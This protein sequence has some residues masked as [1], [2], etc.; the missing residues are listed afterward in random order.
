MIF[1]RHWMALCFAGGCVCGFT[2]G[3]EPATPSGPSSSTTGESAS[4]PEPP[5][6]SG[7]G[8]SSAFGTPAGGS[9]TPE[10][11]AT[12]GEA[13]GPSSAFGSEGGGAPKEAAPSYTI[14]GFYGLP[15][16]TL[17]GGEG[18]LARPRFRFGVTVAQGYDDNIFQSPSD[19]QEIPDLVVVV[20]PGTPDT[21]EFVQETKI[22]GYRTRFF[23]GILKVVPITETKLVPKVIPGREPVTQTIKFPGYPD[24]KG[25]L[26]SRA[27][28]DA[29]V[30]FFTRRSLFT[31]DFQGQVDHYWDR[32]G[33][34]GPDDFSGSLA[35]AYLYSLT[36]RMQVSAAAN[37]AYIS[38]PDFT[39][40]NTPER[41]GASDI[42][43][44]LGRLNL[45]YRATPR[46]TVTASAS[47]NAVIFT[48]K[49][50]DPLDVVG[51]AAVNGD[52]FETTFGVE[53]RYLWNPRYTLLAE[54]RRSFIAYPDSPFLD[55]TTDYAL[56][57]GE[58]R[59]TSRLTVTLRLGQTF[60]TFDESG[61]GSS[62]FYGESS[63]FYRLGPT[64]AL[65]WNSRYG[66]EPPP[67]AE[68]EQ[69][70]YRSALSYLRSFTPR[71]SLNASVAGFYS[72]VT[73]DLLD[74]EQRD[75][76]LSL[77]LSLDYRMSRHLTLNANFTYYKTFSQN[78]N[79]E[80]DRSRLFIG[81]E[82]AF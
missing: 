15:G 75:T 45:A 24:R 60:R 52:N 59:F 54:Y 41:L 7:T 9:Q 14:P 74:I 22:I 77:S 39:R 44:A 50:S 6:E 31:A 34:S 38:Q 13:P 11:P 65:Q 61:S 51:T 71:L 10:S 1:N 80:Y 79:L 25:S 35:L 36:P 72:T 64:S 20:D 55:A 16:T 53:G 21:V 2:F 28:L 78:S 30:Q 27:G 12:G 8:A 48:K 46:L 68:S 5:R 70:T 18:R 62:S 81:G 47:Q 4:T 56:I 63:V 82:Y 76:N 66:F 40:I 19:P 69:L 33:P 23:G 26:V 49:S 58:F 42:I 43:N 37:I 32:P 17:T 73:N 3:Q 67:N 57:G 29:D